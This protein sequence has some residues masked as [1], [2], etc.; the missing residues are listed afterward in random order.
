MSLLLRTSG[1]KKSLTSAP[2]G[3]ILMRINLMHCQRGVRRKRNLYQYQTMFSPRGKSASTFSGASSPSPKP[4]RTILL[5]GYWPPTNTG[6]M[7]SD[8]VGGKVVGSYNVEAFSPAYTQPLG[9]DAP[10]WDFLRIMLPYW[11]KGGGDLQVDYRKT[12][13]FFWQKVNDIK[14]IAIMSFSR[15]GPPGNGSVRRKWYF[16][17]YVYNYAQ[18]VWML[19]QPATGDQIWP[20][21]YPSPAPAYPPPRGTPP[22]NPFGT[23]QKP[24]AWDPPYAGGGVNDFSPYGP[25][26]P[27]PTDPQAGNP[28]DPTENSVTSMPANPPPA[29]SWTR[30]SNLPFGTMATAI[31]NAI[32]KSKVD[33]EVNEDPEI[34][35][36]F[37]SAYMAYHSSWYQSYS[38]TEYPDSACELAGHTHVDLDV[39][40]DDAKI[41][42]AAQL[43]A[44]IDS[45]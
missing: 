45:L 24:A 18:S 5:F 1:L 36:N 30:V 10:F 8:Y 15:S 25:D 40:P 12:S 37:V 19:R 2:K 20:A 13:E 9:W 39:H 34:L 31:N 17:K 23:V 26:G 29:G 32:D 7:L 42:V 11:G 41:A 22:P 38:Q 3:R 6:Y 14:P 16:E 33:P 44:L 4:E 27:H 21:Y 43:D 35:G 28:P